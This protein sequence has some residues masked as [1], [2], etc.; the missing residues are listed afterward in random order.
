MW[1]WLY[2]GHCDGVLNKEVKMDLNGEVTSLSDSPCNGWCSATI[3]GDVVCK[4]CGR[5]QGEISEWN[6]MSDVEKK[7]VVIDLAKRDF[8]I[9]HSYQVKTKPS[10]LG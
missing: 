9:R 5:T 6:Q 10:K 2:N 1:I 4:G 7:L 8:A 3:F